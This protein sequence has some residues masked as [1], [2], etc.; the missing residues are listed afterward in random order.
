MIVPPT[1]FATRRRLRALACAFFGLAALRAAA[2]A[3]A[4]DAP[5]QGATEGVATAQ[6]PAAP[7]AV[8]A[9]PDPAVPKPKPVPESE[10]PAAPSPQPEPAAPAPVPPGGPASPP[11]VDEPAPK[12]PEERLLP[13]LDVFFPEGDFDLRVSRLINS[14]FFEGQVKYNFIKG[15]I[16]AFLR[17]RYY[18]YRRTTQ[19]TVFDSI[20]FDDLNGKTSNDFDRVRGL[21]TLFEWPYSFSQR[22][23]ALA[24]ID[25]ISSNKLDANNAIVR[26]GET[27]TFI[28]LGYQLGTPDE[29]RSSAI[30]GETRARSERLFAAFREFGPGA[31][32]ITG[33]VTYGF[34]LGV[35]DFD[36]VKLEYEAL[37]RFDLTR[38]SFAVGRL[39]GGTFPRTSPIRADPRLPPPRSALDNYQIPRSEF[40]SLNGRD[41]LKGLGESLRGT[42]ELLATWEVYFPWFL[43]EHR[44]FLRADWQNWYWILYA[45]AGTIGFKREVYKDLSEYVPDAGVG[46]ESSFGLRKKYRFFVSA[47]VAKALKGNGDIEARISIKSYR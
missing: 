3:P 20:E 23:F 38:R 8:T 17:Y 18:G 41:N 40:L 43:E 2:Q 21:L 5:A 26:L 4:S 10:P 14:V 27:N 12:P 7:P 19:L 39:R 1:A 9:P 47:I 33:A 30:A 36:Y 24:E 29:S 13:K 25:G 46:F 42:E 32:T 34:D 37:K 44:K 31:A 28:R 22:A 45:G 16:T 15:D 6:P 11:A 35:G